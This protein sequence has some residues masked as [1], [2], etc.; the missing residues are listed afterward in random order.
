ML[1]V[2]GQNIKKKKKVSTL[3]VKN[4][5]LQLFANKSGDALVFPRKEIVPGK[6]KEL[7]KKFVSRNGSTFLKRQR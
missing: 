2:D 5:A 7:K 1:K 6:K 4:P 3:C